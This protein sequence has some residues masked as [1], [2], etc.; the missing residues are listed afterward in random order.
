MD[1]FSRLEKN[2]QLLSTEVSILQRDYN[3]AVRFGHINAPDLLHELK[4]YRILKQVAYSMYQDALR[5]DNNE[6]EIQTFRL[7]A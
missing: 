7:S 5:Y 6:D 3:N 1:R 2:V 4:H